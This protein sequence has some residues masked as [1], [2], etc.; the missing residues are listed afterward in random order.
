MAFLS[1]STQGGYVFAAGTDAP[2]S[3]N[4]LTCRGRFPRCL[5]RRQAKLVVVDAGGEFDCEFDRRRQHGVKIA[6][7][8][9]RGISRAPWLQLGHV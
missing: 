3:R 2:T 1:T 7:P 9:A 6:K 8:L 4:W 5:L